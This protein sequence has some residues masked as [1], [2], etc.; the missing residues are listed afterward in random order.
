V[1]SE[2]KMLEEED[3]DGMERPAAKRV[4]PPEVPAVKQGTTRFEVIHWGKDRGLGQNGGYIAALDDST[5]RE[6]WTLKVYD[7]AY[8]AE[9]EED[10][11]D[12]F[13]E[14]MAMRAAGTLEIADEKGRRYL[15][16]PAT[17][18]VTGA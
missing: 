14:S 17:R 3:D 11:Q 12:V 1:N 6:L 16:D 13:I 15:V 9:L 10:V 7:V 4:G 18:R 8:D 5:G 2:G